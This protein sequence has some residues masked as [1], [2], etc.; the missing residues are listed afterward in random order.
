M[1]MGNLCAVFKLFDLTYF[2]FIILSLGIIIPLTFVFRKFEKD[3][4][5]YTNITL[6]SVMVLFVIL[7][8][9]G[10]IITAKGFNFF[11]M[12]P[13]EIFHIFVYLSIYTFFA[14]HSSWIKF[15]Y[16][17]IIPLSVLSLIFIPNYYLNRALSLELVAFIVINICLIL[18]SIV[19]LFWS[20]EELYKKDILNCFV[21]FIIIVCVAH[22]VNVFLRFSEWGVHVNYMGSMG[23]D[24]DII[25][26]WLY[27][28][29]PVPLVCIMPIFA[30]L[31][32]IQ[33]LMILPFEMLKSKKEK[34]SQIEE[35]VA[36]GNMKAQQEYRNKHKKSKIQSQVLLRSE[37]KARPVEDKK[38][39]HSKNDGFVVVNKQVQVNNKINEEK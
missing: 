9:V 34:Q 38:V 14:K 5:K 16:C 23:E 4:R 26:G 3:T 15:G 21:N 13:I 25:V 31:V 17:V 12:L 33:F 30:I 19:N 35:L 8:Y 7:E 39:T 20:D 1:R 24:Y 32:G 10:R 11:E 27:S 2:I 18:Y 6:L 37:T 29:I 36:L 22:L 28:L